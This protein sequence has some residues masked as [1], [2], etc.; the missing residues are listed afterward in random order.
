MTPQARAFLVAADCSLSDAKTILAAG[1]PRQAA[2]L[3]YYAQFHAAQALIFERS[4]QIAKTHKGVDREFHRH[5]KA[6]AIFAPGFAA[7]LS[8]AYN[9]KEHADY[10]TDFSEPITPDLASRA[11]AVADGFVS[12]VRHA[13]GL[14]PE[15]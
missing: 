8:K 13:I 5:A 4:S 2:R 12:T 1:V 7:Q 11:I 3:A 15:P 10:G 14:H 6:E 9:Y